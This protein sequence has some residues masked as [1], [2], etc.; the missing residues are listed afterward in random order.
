[1]RQ[2]YGA[3]YD[4]SADLYVYFYYRALQLLKNNG[5]FVFIS[6]NK[7]LQ[8]NYGKKLRGELLAKTNISAIVNF[9]SLPIFKGVAAYPMI[10]TAQKSENK[11]TTIQYT[12]VSDLNSPYPLIRE[13]VNKM[14]R[15]WIFQHLVKIRGY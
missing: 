9:G 14:A 4:G 15:S 3:N 12:K 11:S 8:N 7:W 2:V 10:I 6:S 5:V 13:I 1:M